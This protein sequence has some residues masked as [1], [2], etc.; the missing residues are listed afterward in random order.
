[1][2]TLAVGKTSVLHVCCDQFPVGTLLRIDSKSSK[3]THRIVG[4]TST[5]ITVAL[6]DATPEAAITQPHRNDRAY[7]KRKK[8][9]A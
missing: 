1:M 2:K 5:S 6:I 4:I 9:R 3:P 7:L 8:G